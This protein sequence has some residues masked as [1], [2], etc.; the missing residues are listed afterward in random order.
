MNLQQFYYFINIVELGSYTKAAQ[1]LFVTQSSLSHS[2]ADLERELG[3]PLLTKGKGGIEPTEY[4]ESF[5]KHAKVIIPECEAITRDIFALKNHTAG[6][7]RI[8]SAHTL[9]TT[10]VPLLIQ[11]FYEKPENRAIQFELG[12]SISGQTQEALLR[13]QIDIGFNLDMGTAELE[14][15]PVN[16]DELAVLVPKNHP[17]AHRENVCAQELDGAPLITYSENCGTRRV[18]NEIFQH[19]GI[20]PN[21]IQ[22]C[23][24]EHLILGMVSSEM[25]IAVAPRLQESLFYDVAN[26]ALDH[27][28][29][30][31]VHYMQWRKDRNVKPVVRRFLDFSI[32]YLTENGL[33]HMENGPDI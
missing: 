11:V 31:R 19:T 26:V 13:D 21:I 9:A 30:K 10:I 29:W 4:G 32:Q 20:T 8:S 15:F 28:K 5:L 24:T 27:G 17:W 18:I 7:I 6:K 23:E 14:S 22:E 1:K 12:E 33:S 3:V 16:C 2:I 25:G